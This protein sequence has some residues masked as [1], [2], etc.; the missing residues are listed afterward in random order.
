MMAMISDD[1]YNFKI[2]DF[3][4]SFITKIIFMHE[5]FLRALKHPYFHNNIEQ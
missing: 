5:I 4:Y 1:N 2:I 3:T